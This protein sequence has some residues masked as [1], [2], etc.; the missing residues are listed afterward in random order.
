MSTKHGDVIT[1]N[2][3][4]SMLVLSFYIIAVMCIGIQ[5]G[6]RGG[7]EPNSKFSD[8]G[9]GMNLYGPGKTFVR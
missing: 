1:I 2:G 6:E 8:F 5:R 4:V 7:D 3:Q 9:E